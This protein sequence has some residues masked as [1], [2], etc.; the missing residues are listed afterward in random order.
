MLPGINF[1]C[2]YLRMRK[3][4]KLLFCSVG[5]FVFTFI[6]L[7]ITVCSFCFFL[8]FFVSFFLKYF[9][10][11]DSIIVDV[12]VDG[13]ISHFSFVCFELKFSFYVSSTVSPLRFG[14]MCLFF[15]THARTNS[16]SGRVFSSELQ[17]EER[18]NNIYIYLKRKKEM[19]YNKSK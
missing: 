12:V 3:G 6:F 4:R 10:H 13:C 17:L 9:P 11:L 19:N 18:R 1:T 5:R 8:L 7:V 15:L 2:F 16:A 14:T